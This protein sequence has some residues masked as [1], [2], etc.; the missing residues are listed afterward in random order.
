MK[1]SILLGPA[2]AALLV[3][4]HVANPVH[5]QSVEEAGDTRRADEGARIRQQIQNDPVAPTIAPRG[6]DVTMVVF[7]DYQCPYCRKVHPV[8]QQLMR[9]DAKVR[10]VYRD[11][12]IFGPV[13]VQAARAVIAAK[14]QGKHA[15]FN[16]AM[17]QT[18]GKLSVQG[19]RAAANRAGV[20][21]GRLQADLKAHGAEID[22]AIERTGRYA[23][24]MG[25]RG[26]P[27]ILV[28]PYLIPGAIDIAGLRRAVAMARRNS[29]GA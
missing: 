14:Y 26:T 3:G 4:G 28:G 22:G 23:A 13:S 12:P 17:M 10:V 19:I 8:I 5:A 21:W 20:N 7:S 2:A 16:D 29:V 18:S 11:W 25:L 6:A 15:A 9:E 27:G 24:M 1:K